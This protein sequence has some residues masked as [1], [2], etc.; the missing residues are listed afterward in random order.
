MKDDKL[1]E[2]FAD[3]NPQL[4][5]DTDFMKTLQRNMD[6]VEFVKEQTVAL[7]R[8]SRIAVLTSW[9]AGFVTGT[10]SISL[11]KLLG[12][13][14]PELI[15]SMPRLNIAPIAVDWQIVGWIISAAA[16][17]LTAMG[18]YES[19]RTGLSSIRATK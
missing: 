13:S 6:A 10:I 4:A 8:R 5:P 15:I 19:F 14:I 1:T 17:F 2:L 3:F 11:F 12:D 16:C 7:K 18:V 9:I